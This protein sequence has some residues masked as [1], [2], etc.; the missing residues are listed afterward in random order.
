MECKRVP[1]NTSSSTVALCKH[2][3]LHVRSLP[4][5]SY[6]PT[7]HCARL[8]HQKIG[9]PSHLCLHLLSHPRIFAD[10]DSQDPR[11]HPDPAVLGSKRPRSLSKSRGALHLRYLPCHPHGPPHSLDTDSVGVEDELNLEEEAQDYALARSGW[12][13]RRRGHFPH[14]QGGAIQELTRRGGQ[15]RCVGSIDVSSLFCPLRALFSSTK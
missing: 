3:S 1:S 6:S 13:C 10:P 8:L 15:F 12:Y 9:L 14:G 7:A 4:H 11:L 5:E 2:G